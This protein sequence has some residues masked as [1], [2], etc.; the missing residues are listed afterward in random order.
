MPTSISTKLEP[1][2]VARPVRS[3]ASFE[4]VLLLEPDPPIEVLPT[5]SYQL[6]TADPP[7]K[8]VGW[9]RWLWRGFWSGVEWLFGL[10]SLVMGLAILSAVPILQFLA[11][12]YLLE[13]CGRVA[14][15]GKISEG[16]IGVRFA[17][18]LGSVALG[19]LL[20]WIPLWVLAGLN[21]SATIIDTEGSIARWWSFGLLIASSVVIF[22]VITAILCGGKLRYFFWPFNLF[23]LLGPLFRG[24]LFSQARDGLWNTVVRLRLLY[25]FWL[26]F[27]GFI[28]GYLWL[29]LPLL[30][31]GLGHKLP[32]VGILGGLLLIPVV[33]YVPFLQARFARDGALRAFRQPW[34]VRQDFK[35]A[36]IAFIFALTVT[37]T[38]AMP[39][40]LLKIEA[41]PRELVFLENLVFLLFIFPSKLLLGWAYSRAAK[42]DRPRNFFLRWFC[43]L[44]VV[45]VV[46]AYVLVVFTS[47][48]LGWS[49]IASLFEQHAFLLPVPF[50]SFGD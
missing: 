20:W 36:P 10:A 14:R 25:L 22:H 13:V 2:P 38:L 19:T 12:G 50:I 15:T 23:W 32:V 21:T 9:L 4:P 16:F 43:R 34:S 33:M 29:A 8:S 5:S 48:H 28:G 40:Y 30:L 49:G 35:R 47:Q 24:E 37:L 6:E 1:L 11:L 31:L 39:L 42:R 26:G 45:P 18:R 3:A 17:A 27:R 46:V 41:I 44:L 7:V